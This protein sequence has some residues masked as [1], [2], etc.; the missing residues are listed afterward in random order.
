MKEITEKVIERCGGNEK[1][2]QFAEKVVI[3]CQRSLWL[4]QGQT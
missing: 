4:H 1:L 3:Y 2:E